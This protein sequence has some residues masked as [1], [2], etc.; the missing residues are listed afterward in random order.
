MAGV[1]SA[2]TALMDASSGRTIGSRRSRSSRR[3]S[4][5][6]LPSRHSFAAAKS[7]TRDGREIALDRGWRDARLS[8]RLHNVAKHFAGN[9]ADGQADKMRLAL[10]EAYQIPAERKFAQLAQLV[11]GPCRDRLLPRS[12]RLA[13]KRLALD[14]LD[15]LVTQAP[16]L[17][18]VLGVQAFTIFAA[19][20]LGPKPPRLA[21]HIHVCLSHRC[22]RFCVRCVRANRRNRGSR[23]RHFNDIAW[24]RW[25]GSNYKTV[26]LPAELNRRRARA[27]G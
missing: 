21:T 24:R 23:V 27:M 1:A 10:C 9:S 15:P 16:R 5:L 2:S 26:A 18:D 7:R 17:A 4:R 8:T 25:Q 14:F 13:V 11:F 6:G 22:V 12:R 3:T 19:V 20:K